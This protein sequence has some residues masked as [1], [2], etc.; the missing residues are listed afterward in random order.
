MEEE[1]QQPT[2][3]RTPKGKQVIGII[4]QR[5]GGFRMKVRCLDGKSRVC[6]IPGKLRRRLW[7]REGD[8]LLVEPWEYDQDKKGDVIFKYSPTQIVRLKKEG[9]LKGLEESDEF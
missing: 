4:E 5:L 2:R 6:R 8:I 7:T 3:V 1:Q 9:Y